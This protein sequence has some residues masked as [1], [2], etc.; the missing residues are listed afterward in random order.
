MPPSVLVRL[1]ELLSMIGSDNDNGVLENIIFF[2]LIG[3]IVGID[4]EKM[5]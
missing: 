4:D 1:I 5:I 2:G 3:K